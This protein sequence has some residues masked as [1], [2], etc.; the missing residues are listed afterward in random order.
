M[1]GKEIKLCQMQA[2]GMV[3]DGFHNGIGQS[4]SAESRLYPEV[5]Q[6]GITVGACVNIGHGKL[7]CAGRYAILQN[8]EYLWNAVFAYG[9]RTYASTCSFV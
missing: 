7:K 3:F 6:P 8:Q 2:S 4:F 1:A 5:P 9:L